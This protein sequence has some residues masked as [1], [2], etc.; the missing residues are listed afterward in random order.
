MDS[1]PS[2]WLHTTLDKCCSNHFSWN[3][4]ACM[5]AM[6]DES[7][8][9]AL[10]YPD[11]SGRNQGCVRDGNEPSYMTQNPSNFIFSTKKDCCEEHYASNYALCM[12]EQTGGSGKKWYPD[13][14][15]VEK[16][17]KQDGGAPEYMLDATSLLFDDQRDCCEYTELSTVSIDI[18]CSV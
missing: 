12:G 4:A 5:G 14:T 1:N 16:T 7:C 8:L 11:W 18:V 6:L 17:C 3:Y 2:N 10:W 13:W 9:K 15:S